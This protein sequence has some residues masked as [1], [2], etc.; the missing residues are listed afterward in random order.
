M[1]K[2]GVVGA[3][4]VLFSQIGGWLILII[5]MLIFTAFAAAMDV[6]GSPL[7]PAITTEADINEQVTSASCYATL[8]QVLRVGIDGTSVSLRIAMEPDDPGGILGQAIENYLNQ[9]AKLQFGLAADEDDQ[10]YD[11]WAFAIV[12]EED[13]VILGPMGGFVPTPEILKKNTCRQQIPT[14]EGGS[15]TAVL[16][17][18]K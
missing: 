2:K 16:T 12:D 7:R 11:S 1:S 10:A 6:A 18:G 4:A 3:P 15:M 17:L 5:G 8:M 14:I 9:H 13:T